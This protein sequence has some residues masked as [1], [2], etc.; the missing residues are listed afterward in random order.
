MT[1]CTP[2]ELLAGGRDYFDA[3]VERADARRSIGFDTNELLATLVEIAFAQF[4]ALLA[5]GGADK[6]PDQLN[7]PRPGGQR[8]TRRKL[9]PAEFQQW[10][11]DHGY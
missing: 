4:R 6:V 9:S 8:S 10:V 2:A 7:V 5:L 11:R 1:G 3:L